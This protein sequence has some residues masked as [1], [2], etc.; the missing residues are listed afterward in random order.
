V[1]P[2]WDGNPDVILVLLDANALMMPGQF[3][4]DLFGQIRELVGAFDPLVLEEVTGELSGIST[5]RGRHAAAA[6]LG[7]SLAG[8]CTVIPASQKGGPVDEKIARYAETHRCTVVTNDK[9]LRNILLSRGIDVIF[10][11]KQKKLELIR[12]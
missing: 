3:G 9:E 5:G 1:A 4:I 12:S 7:L 11:R 2:D 8:K 6:P 10:I